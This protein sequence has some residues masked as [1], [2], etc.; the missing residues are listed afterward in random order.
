MKRLTSLLVDIK[1][2]RGG[3][4][5]VIGRVC[6]MKKKRKK[7]HREQ[8]RPIQNTPRN[9]QP[10]GDRVELETARK[11]HVPRVSPYLPASIDTGFVEIGHTHRQTNYIMAPCTHP[12]TNREVH[13]AR[14]GLVLAAGRVRSK[15]K[16]KNPA[17]PKTRHEID[18]RPAIATNS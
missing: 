17:P 1:E 18:S 8:F 9:K 3:L 5:L 16:N 7:K 4:I 11:K 10:P 13:E 2:A 15:K 12:C 14:C 6:S